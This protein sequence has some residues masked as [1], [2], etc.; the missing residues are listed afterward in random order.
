MISL[1]LICIKISKKSQTSHKMTKS[2][3]LH[4]KGF[5]KQQNIFKK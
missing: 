4:H 1:L 2:R 3:N 5:K